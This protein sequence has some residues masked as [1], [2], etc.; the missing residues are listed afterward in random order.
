MPL[1]H[2]SVCSARRRQVAFAS[3]AFLLSELADVYRATR[4]SGSP[5]FEGIPPD[6]Y[7]P[8]P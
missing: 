8:L 7:Q 4:G 5:I 2:A 6:F 1:I 3:P